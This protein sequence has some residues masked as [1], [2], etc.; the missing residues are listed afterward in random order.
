MWLPVIVQLTFPIRKLFKHQTGKT[1]CLYTCLVQ[2]K[3]LQACKIRQL[4]IPNIP[5]SIHF[6][7]VYTS[8]LPCLPGAPFQF[9]E[10]LAQ[11]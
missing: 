10:G 3:T 5:H 2:Q 6:H 11:D 7:T 9:F 8:T 1:E 4:K